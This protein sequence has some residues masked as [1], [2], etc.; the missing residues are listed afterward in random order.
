MNGKLRF[1]SLLCV[2]FVLFPFL[3]PYHWIVVIFCNHVGKNRLREKVETYIVCVC[4]HEWGGYSIRRNK[5]IKN[6][7]TFECGLQGQIE[8]FAQKEGIELTITIS[9]FEK[10]KYSENINMYAKV[11]EVDNVG[12]DFSGYEYFFNSIKNESNRYVIL[13]NTSVNSVQVDFLHD[14]IC[15]MENN[16]DVGILGISYCT[17]MIQT[18]IRPNFIPHL[19][20]FFLLTTTQ[21]LREIVALNNGKFPGKGIDHKLLL[22]RLGEIEISRLVQKLGYNLAVVNP[23]D[24]VPFKFTDYKHWNLPKGDIRQFLSEPNKITPISL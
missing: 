2:E 16:L 3:F 22:I 8:R 14:Y 4:V 23:Q 10:Y 5:T 13:T 15:Y 18:L 6:G 21:V 17:K 20:S 9:E 12:F 11:V 7:Q 19:Q 1:Y 24:G